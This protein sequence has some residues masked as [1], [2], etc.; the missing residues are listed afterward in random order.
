M[1]DTTTSAT[2]GSRYWPAVLA[3]CIGVIVVAYNTTAVMTALPAI[4]FSFDMD[5]QT[6]QW[7]VNIYMLAAAVAI[8]T[9]G[10]F[11]DIFGAMRIFGVGLGA[12]AVGSLAIILAGDAAMILIGR[13]F[14]GLGAAGV[15]STSVALVTLA[16]PED[17]RAQALG[18]WSAAVAFGFAIGP[19]IGGLMTDAISWRG[20]FVLDIPL[21]AVAVLLCVWVTRLG[22]APR[23]IE[24]KTR[25]DYLGIALLA[26]ALG[27]LVYGLSS[28]DAAGWTSA[29]TLSLF[30]I[31]ALAG[32][33]FVF[34]E[35]RAPD[36]L[37]Y[38]SLFRHRSYAAG[39]FGMFLTGAM[40]MG[41]LYFFNLFIQAPGTLDFTVFQAGLA[42]LPFTL[43]MFAVSMTVPRLLAQGGFRWAVTIGM[44]VLAAGFWLLHDTGNQTP[45]GDLWWKLLI[46]GIGM[47]LVFSLLP[48]VGLLEL[49][50]E[51]AGQGS[52]IINTFLFV[53]LSM[54]IAAGSIVAV[55]IRHAYIGP[56][57]EK[58][59]PGTS[60][61]RATEI[62]LLHGSKGEVDQ[63]LAQ[64][65]P[66]KAE[67]IRVA[68]VQVLDDAFA[69]VTELMTVLGLV[70]SILCFF[71]LRTLGESAAPEASRAGGA[72]RG[73]GSRDNT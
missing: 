25:I 22:L 13:A 27:T 73:D 17:R 20:I 47:G 21:L 53:G 41:V 72:A 12:F 51:S 16:T 49:S 40:L 34:R 2:H 54:G 28:G 24:T 39:T 57:I 66:E 6:L 29:Q 4:K 36:P 63:I 26:V 35:S 60:D 69:G 68:I 43:A 64:F 71:L 46:A 55:Q 62:T 59:M 58:L 31:A 23:A 15:I 56:I 42:L 37:V 14:Q 67:E 48:R 65:S 18:L 50:D 3:A 61:L 7:V 32:I 70:G 10:R 33:A 11:A 1:A 19:L 45:Y 44:L 30:V 8:A 9:M 5:K 38:F 52:G